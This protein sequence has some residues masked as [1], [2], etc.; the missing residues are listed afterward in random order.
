MPESNETVLIA[1]D[2]AEGGAEALAQAHALAERRGAKLVVC[3]AIPDPGPIETLLTSLD[4]SSASALSRLEDKAT[5]ALASRI[6]RVT[7]RKGVRIHVIVGSPHS[8]ILNEASLVEADWIVVGASRRQGAE[9]LLLGS[10]AAQVVRHATCNVLVARPSPSTDIVVGATDLSDPALP[11]LKEAAAEAEG[12][13]GRLVA[14]HAL[15]LAHPLLSSF[16]PAVVI[17]EKT[18]AALKESAEETLGAAVARFGAKADVEVVQG[19]P[20]RAIVEVA[21]RLKAALVVVGTHGRTGLRRIALGSVAE[22]VVRNAPC[23]VLVVRS[24]MSVEED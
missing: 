23:S 22:G 20:R 17:D 19:A 2:L 5:K 6:E 15:D 3:H 1:D 10:S 9:L 13:G 14:T 16:E 21:K 7:K 4:D 8:V 24:T 12:R 18:A 11:G